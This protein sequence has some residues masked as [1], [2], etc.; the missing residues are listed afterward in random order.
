MAMV[1]RQR[2]HAHSLLGKYFTVLTVGH[3]IPAAYRE[4][5]IEN[6]YDPDQSWNDIWNA[7]NSDEFCLDATRVTLTVGNTGLDGDTFK[8]D[9]PHGQV[10][11]PDQQDVP[12]HRPVHDQHRD[13]PQFRRLLDQ[14]PGQG[15]EEMESRIEDMSAPERRVHDARVQV[16]NRR[17]AATSGFLTV[18]MMLS[19]RRRWAIPSKATFATP[20]SWPTTNPYA[21]T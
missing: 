12:Q 9:I 20:T 16:V 14:S 8:N 18:S 15:S 10:R 11:Y 13:D 17:P 6:Y 7:W 3:M 21:H 2:I 19:G 4:S 5:G 1:L